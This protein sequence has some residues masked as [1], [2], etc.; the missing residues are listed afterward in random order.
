MFLAGAAQ[1]LAGLHG[2]PDRALRL[3]TKP[4]RARGKGV[5]A[6]R[7]SGDRD[8][9]WPGAAAAAS[10]E[11]EGNGWTLVFV[12]DFKHSPW[13]VWSVLTDPDELREWAPFDSTFDLGVPGTTFLSTVGGSRTVDSPSHIREVEAPRKLEY[14]WGP[15]RLLWELEPFGSGTRLTLR[16]TMADRRLVPK[17]AAGWQI[18]LDVAEQFLD[19]LPIGRIVADE[20][21]M[22]DWERLNDEF[23]S[24]FR[25][26]NT[27]WP[28]PHSREG[29]SSS[30]SNGT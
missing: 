20:A 5:A 30:L 17:A 27:G 19:G 8:S 2:P 14:S 11:R 26:P 22:F 6:M 18:C 23:S 12:R 25:I 1:D 3:Q 13:R 4:V 16:H 29:R 10:V 21:R 9:Y 24:R 28:P 7:S 15:D